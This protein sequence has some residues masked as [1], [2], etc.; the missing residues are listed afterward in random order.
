MSAYTILPSELFDAYKTESI[1]L[2][3]FNILTALYH[4]ADFGADAPL[5]PGVVRAMSA[6]RVLRYLRES[7]TRSSVRQMQRQ[8]KRLRDAGWYTWDYEDG[9]KRP[10]NIWLRNF[11]VLKKEGGAGN[12]GRENS[13]VADG[14]GE[15]VAEN[16]AVVELLRPSIPKS[17]MCRSKRNVA[18]GVA[19]DYAVNVRTMSPNNQYAP[20]GRAPLHRGESTPAAPPD[21]R[22]A[23]LKAL[24][25]NLAGHLPSASDGTLQRIIDTHDFDEVKEAV[26]DFIDLTDH[27]SRSDLNRLF[28]QDGSGLDS[29]IQSIRGKKAQQQAEE[30]ARAVRAKERAAEAAAKKQAEEQSS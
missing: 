15:N 17:C 1:S 21:P 7:I 25:Y 4:M 14:D 19:E 22:L 28:G 5:G 12:G 23:E 3:S 18:D 29:V 13:D 16:V 26:K 8:L 27:K 20:Y 2:R 10:Y 30:Q 24:V 9:S 6:E 11:P